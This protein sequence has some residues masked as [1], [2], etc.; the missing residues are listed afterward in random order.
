MAAVGEEVQVQVASFRPQDIVVAAWGCATLARFSED[1]EASTL[2][3]RS[4]CG[5]RSSPYV[6]L[7]RKSNMAVSDL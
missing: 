4:A 1:G 2:K 7:K 6:R 5:V 3:A